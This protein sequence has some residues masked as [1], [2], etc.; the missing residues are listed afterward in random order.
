MK[1]LADENISK[2]TIKYLTSLDFDVKSVHDYKLVGSDDSG[3]LRKAALTSRIIVSHDLDFGNLFVYPVYYSGV[4]IL[5]LKDQSPENTN[6]VL[7]KFFVKV[8]KSKLLTSLTVI[9]EDKIR[10]RKLKS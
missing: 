10:I 9:S 3:I 6:R 4:I 1:L 2:S 5:R 7:K 8:D